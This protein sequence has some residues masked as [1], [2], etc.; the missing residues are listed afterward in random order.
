MNDRRA[1][2]RAMHVDHGIERFVVDEHLLG[3]VFGQVA[4]FGNDHRHRLADET[5]Y[6]A[7]QRQLPETVEAGQWADAHRDRRRMRRDVGEGECVEHAGQGACGLEVD[8]LDAAM[9]D[10]AAH[11]HGVR[12]PLDLHVV[13][14]AAGAGE[15]AWVFTAQRGA[16]DHRGGV[17]RRHVGDRRFVQPFSH[18]RLRWCA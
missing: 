6:A 7:G 8:R 2:E 17:G 15:E 13:D 3:R 14:E 18:R 9:G 4:A 11:D 5:H 16:A 1:F 12:H 10:R